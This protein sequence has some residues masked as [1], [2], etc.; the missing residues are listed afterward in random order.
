VSGVEIALWDILGKSL[1]VPVYR[2]LGGLYRAKTPVFASLGLSGEKSPQGWAQ[3]AGEFVDQ[4][5]GGVKVSVGQEWGFDRGGDE[6]LATVSATREAVGAGIDL[7]VDAHSAFYPHTAAR[8]AR[9]FEEYN[10]CHF[11]EPIAAYDWENLAWI[12]QQTTTPIA[13]GE[14]IYLLAEF[15]RF[16]QLKAVD[17]LQFD[18]IKVGGFTIAR[19]IAALAEACDLPLTLHNYH[20]PVATTVALHFIA[21]TPVCRY[22]QEVRAYPHPL[23][24][25]VRNPPLVTDGCLSPPDDPG[26][27]LELDDEEIDRFAIKD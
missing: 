5:Y 21:S 4:G 17:I 25:I 11:E 15:Q 20:S 9:Q 2:L 18:L 26:L 19:K 22:R 16:L 6:A 8:I 13:A 23:A 7:L 3:A 27:G 24:R 12:R 14:Q 1:G 10:V